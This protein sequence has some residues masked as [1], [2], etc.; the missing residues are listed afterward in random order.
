MEKKMK[1]NKNL[2]KKNSNNINNQIR[3][4][5]FSSPKEIRT[6]DASPILKRNPFKTISSK[7][8]KIE[9]KKK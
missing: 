9:S 8:N 7:S 6:I 3:K 4:N 1:E 2:K 5:N